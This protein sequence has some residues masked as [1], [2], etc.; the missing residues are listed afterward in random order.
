MHPPPDPAACG[1]DEYGGLRLSSNARASLM[2]RLAGGAPAPG[3]APGQAM[4][5]MLPGGPLPPPP[6]PLAPPQAPAVQLGA[7]AQVGGAAVKTSHWKEQEKQAAQAGKW[8]DPGVGVEY[9]TACSSRRECGL[10]Y[11]TNLPVSED[12]SSGVTHTARQCGCRCKSLV[13][14]ND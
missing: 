9:V 3:A 2:T 5:G 4:P 13:L 7:A 10:P 8:V 12:W 1:A 11:A 14:A 6:A